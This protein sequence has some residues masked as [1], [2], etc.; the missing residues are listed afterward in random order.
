MKKLLFW[1]MAL[2]GAI[3]LTGCSDDSPQDV[4]VKWGNALIAEDLNTANKYSTEKMK[5][6]NGMVIGMMSD[7]KAK[8]E[9]CAHVQKWQNGQVKIEGDTATVFVKDPKDK[10]AVTLKKVDGKWKVEAQKRND[11]K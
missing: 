5:P 7:K 6:L 1:G 9:I 4:A 3:L 11:D 2:A 8:D 10:D